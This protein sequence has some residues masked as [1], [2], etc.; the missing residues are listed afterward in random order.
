MENQ[1]LSG[2]KPI[3][4]R[5]GNEPPPFLDGVDFCFF[6]LNLARKMTHLM[7]KK[8]PLKMKLLKN[9]FLKFFFQKKFFYF[10]KFHFQRMFSPP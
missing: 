4:L 7:G 2:G 3:P 8:H 1:N 6:K 9:I 5:G 10:Q